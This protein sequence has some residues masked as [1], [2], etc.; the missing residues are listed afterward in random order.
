[1]LCNLNRVQEQKILHLLIEH[2]KVTSI[3]IYLTRIVGLERR[4]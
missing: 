2:Y 1:M 3:L 4:R